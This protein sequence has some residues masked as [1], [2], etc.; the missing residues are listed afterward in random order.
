MNQTPAAVTLNNLSLEDIAQ[1]L[2]ENAR[3]LE[4]CQLCGKEILMRPDQRFCSGRCRTKYSQLMEKLL[5]E[6]REAE[7]I[8]LREEVGR[9]KQ[10]LAR[11]TAG[12]RA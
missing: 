6:Q 1:R 11:L 12:E 3:K 2:R 7:I 5:V 4:P 10:E 8:A 9:L